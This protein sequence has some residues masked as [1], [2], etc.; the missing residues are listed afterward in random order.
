MTGSKRHGHIKRR[1]KWGGTFR[2]EEVIVPGNMIMPLAMFFSSKMLRSLGEV[3]LRTGL[4]EDQVGGVLRMYEL[5]HSLHPD[6]LFVREKYEY[7]IG[8]IGTGIGEKIELIATTT[9]CKY[10]RR[11]NFED[12]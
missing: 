11:Q 4:C 9:Y 12:A 8:G 2:A 5:S 1:L 3:K 7:L 6:T 10:V